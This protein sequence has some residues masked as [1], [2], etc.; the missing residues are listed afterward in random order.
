V[1]ERCR[2]TLP[3]NFVCSLVRSDIGGGEQE[4]VWAG[5][6]IGGI[7]NVFACI[8][9]TKSE[10]NERK[11][12]LHSSRPKGG[13]ISFHGVLVLVGSDTGEVWAKF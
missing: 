9:A 12:P 5:T 4:L 1:Y 13:E 2:I 10:S 11:R 8:S 7:L 3:R 6:F